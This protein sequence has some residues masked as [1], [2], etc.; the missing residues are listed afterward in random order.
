M[1]EDKAKLVSSL[2]TSL[3]GIMLFLSLAHFIDFNGYSKFSPLLVLLGV[4]MLFWPNI[5]LGYLKPLKVIHKPFILTVSHI[6]IFIGLKLYLDQYINDWWA[7]FFVSG[8]ILLNYSDNIA[9]QLLSW[10]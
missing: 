8:I 3:A 2:L 7:L 9:K 4:L 5:F 1:I 10:R 6:L